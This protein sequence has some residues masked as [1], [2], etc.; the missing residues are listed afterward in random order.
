MVNAGAIG[1]AVS[2]VGSLVGALG[3]KS[4][5]LAKLTITPVKV[6]RPQLAMEPIKE[7]AIE[8]LF[9]PRSYSITK[10]VQWTANS[11]PDPNIP[12]ITA[13]GRDP[14][15]RQLNA[16]IL[17]FGGGGSRVLT[18]N[19]F[20]DVTEAIERNNKQVEIGDVRQETNKIA[21][22][23]RIQRGDGAEEPPP[24]CMVTW[25][26]EPKNR[27]IKDDFPFY[28]VIT[29]LTQNFTLFRSDGR[30]VRAELTVVLTEFANPEQDKRLIDPELTTHLVMRGDTLSSLAAKYY[31]NPAMWRVIATENDLDDPLHLEIGQRLRIPKVR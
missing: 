10:T 14:T 6:T 29:N 22:L 5:G 17:T 25:G 7:K 28:G 4:Q 23:T 18:L 3:A 30:P 9:N 15:D 24:V 11:H 8:V 31:R 2:A 20:F 26:A 27:P 13:A 21:Q 16:P 19:L 1:A 12:L